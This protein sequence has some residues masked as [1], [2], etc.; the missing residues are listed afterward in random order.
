MKH[1]PAT[2]HKKGEP[3]ITIDPNMP[4]YNKTAFAVKKAEAARA[5]IQKH[6]LPK[7]G[8]GQKNK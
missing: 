1:I 8:M 7:K 3:A 2:A 6:G 4:D 5:F